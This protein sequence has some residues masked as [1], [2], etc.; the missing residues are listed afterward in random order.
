MVYPPSV[1]DAMIRMYTQ[2][3]KSIRAIEAHFG[4]SYAGVHR[5]LKAAKVQF[6]PR[7]VQY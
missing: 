2:D 1:R 6:R 4:V 7:G 5:A 3:H